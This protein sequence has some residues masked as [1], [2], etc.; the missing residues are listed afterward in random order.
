MFAT[1]LS[2]YIVLTKI[3]TTTTTTIT[4]TVITGAATIVVTD[5]ATNATHRS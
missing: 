2:S 1:L 4:I 5:D 3:T